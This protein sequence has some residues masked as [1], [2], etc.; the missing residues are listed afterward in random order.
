MQYVGNRRIVTSELVIAEFLNT[1]ARRGPR[2]RREAAEAALKLY[3]NPNMT[4]ILLRDFPLEPAIERYADRLD[5]RWSLVDC[6][7]FLIMEELGITEAL[8]FDR[9]FEPAGFR[10]LLRDV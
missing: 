2:S 7:S 6:H 8:A 10:A 1:M 9:D 5:Q 3:L 4:V